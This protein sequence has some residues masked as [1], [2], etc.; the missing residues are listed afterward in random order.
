MKFTKEQQ[1]AV[2]L[3]KR[4]LLVAAAAGS[5]KTAV[6]V[7][8]IIRLVTEGEHPAD[9]DRLLVMTFTKAAAAQMRERIE[10]ALQEKLEADPLNAHL[11][12]QTILIH[13]APITTIDSFCMSV[14]QNHFNEIDLDPAF[15]VADEGE[16]K[17]LREEILQ[18]VL[19][20]AYEEK[21]ERFL[22]FIESFSTKKNDANVI[23]AAA[24]LYTYAQS[25]PFPEEWLL[26]CTRNYDFQ[27]EK[28]LLA[29]PFMQ[30]FLAGMQ[31]NLQEIEREAEWNLSLC[32]AEGGPYMYETAVRADLESIRFL[33]RCSDFRELERGF[34]TLSYTALSRKSDPQTDP[35]RKE[36]VKAVRAGIKK[37]LEKMKSRYFYTDLEQ[38]V[39]DM[40]ACREN[41]QELVHLTLRFS[42]EFAAKKRKKNIVDFGDLE[43]LALQILLS[44]QEGGGYG[45][46]PT[47]LS[48]REFFEEVLV[49]EYQDS[50]MVQE[51]L[52]QAVSRETEGVRNL[53]MVGDV[54]QSIYKFRLACPEIFMEKYG[55]YAR[56][57]EGGGDLRI[58]LHRNFRSRSEVIDTVNFF[59][60]QLMQEKVGGIT[61][62]QNA[63]L[64]AGASFEHPAEGE[65]DPYC[66]ELILIEEDEE[67]EIGAK[68]LEAR[69]VAKRIKE[70]AGSFP[71]GE[72]EP[73]AGHMAKYSDIVILLRSN[74]GWDDV[75]KKVLS[76]EGI[77]V[78]VAS[79]TG[80]FSALEIVTLLDF[81]T[82]LNNPRD[83]CALAAV[84]KG[85]FGGFSD[86]ELAAVRCSSPEGTFYEAVC[87][88]ETEKVRAFREMVES[89]RAD[90]SFTPIHELLLKIIRDFRYDHKIGA[91]PRG[92]MRRANVSI[93]LKKAADFERTSYKGLFHF[94]RYI[95]QLKKYEV[96]YGEADLSS[97]NEDCVRIMS[98]HKSKGLEFPICFLCGLSKRFNRTDFNRSLVLDS[99]E[100]ISMNY[101]NPKLR[102]KESTVLKNAVIEKQL[103][104]NMGEELRILYVAMT[105]AE[106][107]LI[108]TGTVSP[109]TFPRKLAELSSLCRVQ[110]GVE[111]GAGSILRAGTYLDLILAALVRSRAATG[112]LAYA[113]LEPDTENVLWHQKVPLAVQI[114]DLFGLT[115]SEVLEQ[116]VKKAS[117]QELLAVD[118]KQVYHKETRDVLLDH[119]SYR[120]PYEHS[121]GIYTKVSVSDLKRRHLQEETSFALVTEEEE[122]LPRF[123]KRERQQDIRGA[124]RG[125]VYH[126]VM[127]LFDFT[128]ERE[129]AAVERLLQG[130]VSGGYMSAADLEAVDRQ[131]IMDFLSSGLAV[132]MGEAQRHQRLFCEQ[133]FVL[134]CPASVVDPSFSEEETVLVQ[135]IIDVYFE[136]EDGLVVADY[137]TDRVRTPE[138]LAERY[139]LQLEY[140]AQALSRLTGRKVK[141]KIIYSFTLGCE[142]RV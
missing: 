29:K 68:E 120:Y 91:M 108:M 127:E 110:N 90:L 6:L 95:E 78:S 126:K 33:L 34:A 44:P 45:P 131:D 41:V 109:K 53:F 69:T 62:D 39:S 86:E 10:A 80:Y 67:K 54:K 89:Y 98:I 43:H 75:F 12:R 4:N 104:E 59:F 111:L 25:K 105:R 64:A 7:N 123:L 40:A 112:L 2:D 132:R 118:T 27:D 140:Y 121:E 36:E 8:R 97:G 136:E 92:E 28:E 19:E 9:I 21:T 17:L 23:E 58:D 93:L 71:V 128:V 38:M 106:E 55:T 125:T 100:G 76:E 61:Y 130:F 26:D 48:Y 129:A 24:Q 30:E 82:L 135:G 113:E 133:P 57:E 88:D 60:S 103:R 139:R 138:E 134:G 137:K 15:R 79:K 114:T 107:K 115:G 49:D 63:A 37:S 74:A 56:D 142:I 51:Y 83:D 116:A 22:A 65:E 52:L 119:F 13:T 81:L 32:L 102:V 101:V 14:L 96:D 85:L 72:R 94:V 124:A 5:G 70:L 87:A 66:S 20:E 84:M 141:E 99:E 16:L 122:I 3:G 50:N 18:Q 1:S 11:Q 117:L 47:A 46:S 31:E 35:A 42:E 73:G 77:P